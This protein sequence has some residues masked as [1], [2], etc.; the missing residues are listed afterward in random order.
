MQQ[1]EIGKKITELR[2]TKGLTQEELA[3]R[4]GLNV[5]SIQRIENGEVNPRLSTLKILSEI[6]DY[7]FD[8]NDYEKS[9]FWLALLHFTNF[10]PVAII[11]LLIILFKKDDVPELDTHGKDVLN[12]QISMMIY[13]FASSMLIFVLIGLPILILLGWYTAF[14]TIFNTVRVALD[15]SYKYPLTIQFLK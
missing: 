10:I 15:Y 1:P 14:I 4:C 7:N 11:P 6:F 9:R 13:L 5:R 3:S 2:K 8:I 12:F